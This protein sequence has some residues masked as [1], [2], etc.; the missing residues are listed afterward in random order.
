MPGVS[1][2]SVAEVGKSLDEA[3]D[4]EPVHVKHDRY[5]GPVFGLADVRGRAHYFRRINDHNQ[6]DGTDDEYHVW[7]AAV[8]VVLFEV[9]KLAPLRRVERTLRRRPGHC[10]YPTPA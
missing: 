5:D 3:A 1:P 6:H 2:A 10:G 9:Q 7:P 4:W 8:D